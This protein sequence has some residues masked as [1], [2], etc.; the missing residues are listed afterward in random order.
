[1][2]ENAVRPANDEGAKYV[3]R[4]EA[5]NDNL[6]AIKEAHAETCKDVREEIT[7]V[8]NGAKAKGF[9][10]ATIKAIVKARALDEKARQ[11]RENLDLSDRDTFDSIRHS[12][13]DLAELPLGKAVLEDSPPP[14]PPA[15][16][17]IAAA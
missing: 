10:K 9:S 2:A 3:E 5:L 7:D 8:L 14:A 15:P 17:A 12:L 4:I 11:A 6:E 16:K 1:M 13:G